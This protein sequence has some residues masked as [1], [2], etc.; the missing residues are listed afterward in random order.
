[1]VGVVCGPLSYT[2][3]GAAA[4]SHRYQVFAVDRNGLL[5]A[6]SAAATVTVPGAADTQAPQ[7]P[8]GVAVSLNGSNQPVV[9]WGAATDLP[10]PGGVGVGAYW[11]VRDWTTQW[12]VSSA[13]PLSY[14]D[15]G[16]AAGSHR[17]QVFAV[18]RNNQIGAGSTAVTIVKP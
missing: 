4:G 8:P 18:D 12:L 7:P 17:Y 6:G 11:V 5:G 3:T 10:N 14:T 2:D 13:G 15:T 16:A 9:T 1:M